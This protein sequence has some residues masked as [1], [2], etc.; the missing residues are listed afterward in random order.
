[1]GIIVITI[2]SGGMLSLVFVALKA[3]GFLRISHEQE[4]VGLDEDEFTPTRAYSSAFNNGAK[5]VK[6][7]PAAGK[8]VDV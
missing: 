2:W 8:E 4:H 1:V 5:P 3:A 6:V 7:S